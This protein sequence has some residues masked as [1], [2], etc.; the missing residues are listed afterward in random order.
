MLPSWL[1]RFKKRFAGQGTG[2]PI[3]RLKLETLEDRSVPAILTWTGAD[4][5]DRNI[6]GG[7]I[8][9]GN[10]NW[11]DPLNWSTFQVP[12]TGDELVFPVIAANRMTTTVGG[13]NSA[14]GNSRMDIAGLSISKLTITS[15]GYNII[16]TFNRPLTITGPI[17]AQFQ[18]PSGPI[19]VS[20]RLSFDS[21]LTLN[22]ESITVV[23]PISPAGSTSLLL[24]S[25]NIADAP[26]VMSGGAG[27]LKDGNGALSLTGNNS[28]SNLVQVSAGILAAGSTNALGSTASGTQVLN[29][30]TLSVSANNLAESVEITGMGFNNSGA[31]AGAGGRIIGGVALN[32]SATIGGTLTIDGVISGAND[33][34]TVG[35]IT[36]TNANTYGGNT[37]VN[38]GVLSVSNDAALSRT[39][40]ATT[41]TRVAS[42]ATLQ[43]LGNRLIDDETIYLNGPG[44]GGIGALYAGAAG[45]AGGSTAT[46]Q[47][48]SDIILESSA[49]IGNT[50]VA[51]LLLSGNLIGAA[52]A[53]LT[54][55]GLGTVTFP[56]ANPN[57]GGDVFI[58]NGI[59]VMP[60]ATALG[61]KTAAGGPTPGGAITVNNGGT[62]LMSGQ[63]TSEKDI[64][65]NGPGYAGVNADGLTGGA[66]LRVYDNPLDGI[67]T[68]INYAGSVTIGSTTHIATDAATALTISG[69]IGGAANPILFKDGAGA[70]TLTNDNTFLGLLTLFAG[71]TTITSALAL[72]GAGGAGTTVANGASLILADSLTVNGESLLLT[73]VPGN[74]AFLTTSGTTLW[75]G[76]VN[77]VGNGGGEA[78]INVASGSLEFNNVVSGDALLR[79][80][81]AGELRFTGTTSNGFNGTLQID[82]GT[83]GLGKT[84]PNALAVSGPIIVGDGVGI[85][86]VDMLRLDAPN[87]IPDNMPI[88][89]NS[90]GLFNL[91]NFNETIG[92]ATPTATALT[93]AGGEVMT[94]SATLTVNGNIATFGAGDAS[95]IFGNLSLGANSRIFS[96]SPTPNTQ[97]SAS[98]NPVQF[99]TNVTFTFTATGNS[100]DPTPAGRV[101]F[102]SDG[103]AISSQLLLSGAGTQT[104]IINSLS[105]GSHVISATYI[106][107]T[108]FSP[109][110]ITLG[111]PLWW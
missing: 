1:S 28:F 73:S 48:T 90:S 40:S 82:I 33:L 44:F 43:L 23:N 108:Y 2:A 69:V 104:F 85:A 95:R 99:G 59:I 78:D 35:I 42:G 65:L 21:L 87:Q 45:G 52:T 5:I 53:S 89:I 31:L 61:P 103:V 27:I 13:Y 17:F 75:T 97:L 92:G 6:G 10:I 80:I 18:P 7:V 46:A 72:G 55:V 100:G 29:G 8:V 102:F 79:K 9:A 62:L 68:A 76:T 32:T 107:T 36:L 50:D 74:P 70:L 14:T 54:K 60:V 24:I 38:A 16:G 67:P 64:T 49:S 34:T 71:T 63:F 58:N 110:T 39:Q 26:G 22:S 11:S 37:F 84:G 57:F 4:V 25:G 20:S 105:A 83:V 77:L 88:T 109:T 81:G 41:F 94:G 96:F 98:A 111:Q 56:N 51:A 101:Q 47:V 12:T 91:N 30:A 19:G 3:R 15:S 106:P 93:L 86:N 66:A